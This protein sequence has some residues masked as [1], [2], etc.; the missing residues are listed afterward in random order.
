MDN[1]RDY[2]F[3]ARQKK[4]RRVILTCIILLA[5]AAGCVAAGFLLQHGLSSA[6]ESQTDSA[7][8]EVMSTEPPSEPAGT[9]PPTEVPTE[10][11]TE[12]PTE[13]SLPPQV[14]PEQS[15]LDSM[16]L[17]EKICQLFI[18]AP[19][20]LSDGVTVTAPEED[21]VDELMEYPIGGIVLFSQNLVD[22]EQCQALVSAYQSSSKTPLFICVDE[23]GGS[24]SRLGSKEIMGVTHFPAMGKVDETEDAAYTVGYTLGKELK[25]LGFNLDFA[26]VA[27]VNTNPNNPVIGNRAFSNDPEVTAK[28]VVSCVLGFEDGGV[29]SCIKHFPGHGDTKEDSHTAL[30][31]SQKTLEQLEE[32]E[33]IPFRAGITQGVPMIMAGHISFPNVTGNE[34]PATLSPEIITGLL[35]EHLGYEGVVI[36]DAMNMGAITKQYPSGEAAVLALQAGCD[37]ILM[38]QDLPAAVDAVRKAL[39]DGSLTMERLNESVMRILKLKLDYGIC[40][41]N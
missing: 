20:A 2:T 30:A 10:P 32:A 27:D 41:A 40:P 15:L 11:P 4:L 24:V 22:R 36:T 1:N 12:A 6:A 14:S 39:E 7:S 26:P 3:F 29:I 19:E 34:I 33:L 28:M 18:V 16:S 8:L 25:A 13:A 17:V 5:V 21:F 9:Q 31:T 23:E 37:L 38:P 35:R